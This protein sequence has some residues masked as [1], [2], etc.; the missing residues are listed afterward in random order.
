MMPAC[1]LACRI[2]PRAG[3]RRNGL[4]L[5]LEIRCILRCSVSTYEFY[6]DVDNQLGAIDQ[7]DIGIDGLFLSIV[8]HWSF[9]TI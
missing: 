4:I 7:T 1:S 6:D 3:S 8:G 9:N 2:K 5:S